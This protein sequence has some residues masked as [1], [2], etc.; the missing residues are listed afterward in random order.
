MRSSRLVLPWPSW[1]KSIHSGVGTSLPS[2]AVHEASGCTGQHLELE[3]FVTGAH[4]PSGRKEIPGLHTRVKAAGGW[5]PPGW[6]SSHTVTWDTKASGCLVGWL[7]VLLLLTVHFALLPLCMG[8]I[9]RLFQISLFNPDVC[10]LNKQTFIV[11]R[12]YHSPLSV[13]SFCLVH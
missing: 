5:P 11:P 7:R 10:V 12:L 9:M 2:W 3:A 6:L 13:L 1:Q 8:Y 4:E